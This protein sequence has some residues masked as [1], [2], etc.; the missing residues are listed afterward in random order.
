M[1]G[2]VDVVMCGKWIVG[3]FEWNTP[4][5]NCATS[6]SYPNVAAAPKIRHAKKIRSAMR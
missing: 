6:W 1:G 3:V 4:V 5:M 2:R